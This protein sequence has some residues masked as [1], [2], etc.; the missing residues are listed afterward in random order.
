MKIVVTGMGVISP[1]GNSVESFWSAVCRG[2][3]A[4]RTI[5][6]FPLKDFTFQKAGEIVDFAPPAG[7]AVQVGDADLSTRYMVAAAAQAVEQ[8]HLAD[9]PDTAVVL[10]T[11]FGGV[12]S[13]EP[14]LA[15][16]L[17]NT[18]APAGSFE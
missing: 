4:I 14:F 9:T 8:A 18:A 15:W 3:S 16:A 5:T 2:T 13:A 17:G 12:G 6:R 1:L 10:S 7:L 11:N